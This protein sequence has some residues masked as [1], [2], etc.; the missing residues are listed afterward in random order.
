[1]KKWVLGITGGIGSGKTAVTRLFINKGIEAIDADHAA[2]WVVEPGS[3]ALIRITE[4]FGSH[5]LLADGQLN[6]SALRQIIFQNSEQRVWLEKLLHPIIRQEICRFLENACSPYAILVSPLL[7]ESGQNKLVNRIL[8]ID[9]SEAIQISRGMQR[10]NNSA[11][12]IKA[13]MKTQL[14]REER[15]NHADDIIVNEQDLTYLSQQV[16]QLHQR[17]LKLC[18]S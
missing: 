18:K 2:R 17:Y 8:V 10:D 9:T 4:H 7:L 15:L 5:I 14:A 12:Q 16:D 13:I 6:R 11:E 3:P 1:M